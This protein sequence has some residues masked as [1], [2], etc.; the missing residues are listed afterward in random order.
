MRVDIG[1]RYLTP[2]GLPVRVAD[3]EAGETMVLQ[4]LVSDNRIAVP[5]GYP[6][7]GYRE[8]AF[9]TRACAYSRQP[10]RAGITSPPRPPKVLAPIIDALLLAG[11]KTMR[12]IVREVKR[13]A[14][15]ACLGRDLKANVRAR[16]LCCK[17]PR[18]LGSSSVMS[19]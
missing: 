6:L 2:T 10:K 3:I 15:T 1:N 17:I 7:S 13:K 5:P 16:M 8:H 12:G 4:S 11:N 18:P 14:G 19:G 9:E